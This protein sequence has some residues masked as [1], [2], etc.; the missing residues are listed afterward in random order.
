MATA[1][2]HYLGMEQAVKVEHDSIY[3]T[4]Q[5]YVFEGGLTPL[6]WAGQLW[7]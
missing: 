1:Y 5:I 6:Q 7:H 2:G 4:I 3:L